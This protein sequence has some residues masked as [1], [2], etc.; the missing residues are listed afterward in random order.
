MLLNKPEHVDVEKDEEGEGTSALLSCPVDG[1]ICT[2][3]KYYNLERQ[4]LCER[5]KF[6][7]EK[8]ILLDYARLSY[9]EKVQRG[10]TA[11]PALTAPTS[12]DVRLDTPLVQ[13]WALKGTKKGHPFQR[14]PAPVP[15]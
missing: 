14:Q 2:Y 8:Y 9:L 15:E 11:Q 1:C 13:G 3:Q 4:L 6:V 10:F 5:C 7:S 12:S